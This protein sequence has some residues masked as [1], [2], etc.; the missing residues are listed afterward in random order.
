M[1]WKSI[2]AGAVASVLGTLFIA[3]SASA[4]VRIV[5]DPGGEVLRTFYEMRATGERIVIDG[6]CLSACTLLTGIVPRDHVCVTRRAV[7]GFHSASYYNDVSRS[8]VPTRA[9]T[10]LVMRLYPPEIR[11]WIKPARRAHAAS[12]HDAWPGSGGA[13]PVLPL[14]AGA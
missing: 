4:D 5:N 13:L 6:P 12:H 1:K 9:G 14:T 2:V 3:G 11:A 10:R 8:L 7:L